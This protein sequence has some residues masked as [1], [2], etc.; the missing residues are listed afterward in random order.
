[1]CLFSVKMVGQ[2]WAKA[3]GQ[4]VQERNQTITATFRANFTGVWRQSSW[5]GGGALVTE[6][7]FPS[8]KELYLPRKAGIDRKLK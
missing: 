8:R 5:A 4:G 6:K 7:A 3:Q 1:M 2:V